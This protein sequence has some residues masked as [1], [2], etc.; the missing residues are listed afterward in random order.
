M[1]KAHQH[2]AWDAR[3]AFH[4]AT[5]AVYAD[6]GALV[7]VLKR[8][9]DLRVALRVL[10]EHAQ[11]GAAPESGDP[12]FVA[13]IKHAAGRLRSSLATALEIRNTNA[14]SSHVAGNGGYFGSIGMVSHHDALLD[15]AAEALEPDTEGAARSGRIAR[16]QSKSGVIRQDLIKSAMDAKSWARTAENLEHEYAVALLLPQDFPDEPIYPDSNIG[17]RVSEDG[18]AYRV[19]TETL[20][21]LR[22]VLNVGVQVRFAQATRGLDELRQQLRSEDLDALDRS[23]AAREALSSAETAVKANSEGHMCVDGPVFAALRSAGLALIKGNEVL[24]HGEEAERNQTINIELAKLETAL[25]TARHAFD[26]APRPEQAIYNAHKAMLPHLRN[27]LIDLQEV[28]RLHGPLLARPFDQAAPRYGPTV[29]SYPPHIWTGP[30]GHDVL[31]QMATAVLDSIEA[32][33][34]AGI[35]IH[36]E[37]WEKLRIDIQRELGELARRAPPAGTAMVA[38]QLANLGGLLSSA[39]PAGSLSAGDR[40]FDK[41]IRLLPQEA[42]TSVGQA[43]AEAGAPHVPSREE[44][45]TAG[46][47]PQPSA[48][49]DYSKSSQASVTSVVRALADIRK[50]SPDTNP[51]KERIK[52]KAGVAGGAGDRAIECAIRNKLISP[53][54]LVTTIGKQFLAD[55][56]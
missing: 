37:E 29:G 30:S 1:S 13:D 4:R 54:L 21:H 32:G 46:A 6:F 40:E 42:S 48:P 22:A 33:E 49:F 47:A 26:A 16:P 55:R 43:A 15:G 2:R 52:E 56:S 12:E 51:S 17:Q 23:I 38:A 5:I 34:D 25:Q 44:I 7:D 11:P 18:A 36:D 31:A 27:R 53:D 24:F 35:V 20:Q 50:R 3:D 14:R 9:L 45:G 8:E 10:D 41:A 39:R 28:L 19:G